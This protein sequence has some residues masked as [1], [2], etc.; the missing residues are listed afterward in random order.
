MVSSF[1]DD[2][3]RKIVELLGQYFD[4]LYE[5]DTKKFESVFHQDSHLYSSDGVEIADWPRSVYFE[6]I[7]NRPSPLAQNLPRN[8]KIISIN[9][10]GPS[11]AMAIV[12]C[13]I[14]PKYFTDYLTIL[15]NSDGW[16]II[17]KTFH[18]DIHE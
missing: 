11:T 16:R 13:A 4:G 14:P 5:G 10:S 17:S 1:E 8:D 7:K 18:T 6:M 3:I 9:K 15:K 2:D 12:S